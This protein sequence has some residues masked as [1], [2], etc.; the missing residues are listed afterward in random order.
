MHII[1]IKALHIDFDVMKLEV[2]DIYSSH[3]H[4]AGNLRAGEGETFGI[5]G[6]AVEDRLGGV[7]LFPLLGLVVAAVPVDIG[8]EFQ[9]VIEGVV[10]R[11]EADDMRGG[12]GSPRTGLIAC[13]V[14]VG[15]ITSGAAA[16]ATC[17]AAGFYIPDTTFT[18]GVLRPQPA[19]DE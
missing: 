15:G 11:S 17:T 5:S 7:C 6:G 19:R 1:R 8:A 3:A 4:E 2:G 12:R 16:G 13:P 18:A 10:A 14:D 9:R